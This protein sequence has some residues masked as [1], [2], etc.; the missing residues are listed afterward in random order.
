MI[1]LM[2]FFSIG[3]LAGPAYGKGY[4]YEEFDGIM[5]FYTPKDTATYRALLPTVFDLPDEPVVQAFVF[6]YYKM[7]PWAIKPY[8]EAAIFLLAKYKGEE[9][10]H[11]LTMPVTTDDAR[12]GGIKYLGYPK[13]LAEV[14]FIREPPFFRGN[15]KAN[16]KTILKVSLDTKD[17]PI[18][19]AERRWF[20][21]LA[22]IPPLNFLGGKLVKPRP[23]GSK[24]VTLL[25]LSEKYSQVFQ[26][27]TGQ[28][29]WAASPE[30]ALKADDWRPAA[31]GIEVKEIVLAYYFQN[32]YGFSFGKPEEVAK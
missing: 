15:L 22:G 16:G 31:F 30:A 26:V 3:P 7:A 8:Q 11:C 17:H 4:M 21:R 20:R 18:T 9:V 27:A 5:I 19:D 32:K 6:D 25:D 23:G 13:V 10:W 14:N 1:G 2:I 24:E 12:I 29:R 28:A